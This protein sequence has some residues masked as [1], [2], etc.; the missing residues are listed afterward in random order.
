[1]CSCTM[2]L[3]CGSSNGDNVT[4][5]ATALLFAM[6]MTLCWDLNS[7]QTPAFTPDLKEEPYELVYSRTDLCGGRL[8]TAVPTAI[9]K[10]PRK[11]S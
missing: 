11:F 4:R 2:S 1:M 3:I 7:S 8:E 10:S 5:E 6:R 9:K